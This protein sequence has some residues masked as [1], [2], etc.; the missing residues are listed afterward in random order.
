VTSWLRKRLGTAWWR[1]LHIAAT[2]A[3]ILAMVHGIFAGTDAA[4]PWLW[5]TYVTTSCI[6]LFLLMVRALTV[7]NRPERKP[8][9]AGVQARTRPPGRPTIADGPPGVEGAR[10]GSDDVAVGSR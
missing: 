6:V 3:F 9:P 8:L 10:E 5:W 7:G 2:P 4:Q 1:A